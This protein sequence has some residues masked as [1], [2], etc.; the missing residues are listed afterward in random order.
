MD[1]NLKFHFLYIDLNHKE[2]TSTG[3]NGEDILL[4]AELYLCVS[5]MRKAK[6]ALERLTHNFP[7]KRITSPMTF[8]FPIR[9]ILL[10][11]NSVAIEE[12]VQKLLPVIAI[13]KPQA[14]SK[15][16]TRTCIQ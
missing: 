8:T 2:H 3:N 15:T 11:I 4:C 14:L 9:R 5:N 12:A 7:R 6:T 16:S 10:M 1:N 13:C